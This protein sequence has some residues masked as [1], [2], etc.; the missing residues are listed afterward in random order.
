V[1]RRRPRIKCFNA[2]YS[3]G[4]FAS[5]ADMGYQVVP[6]DKIVGSVG[7]CQEL[8]QEFRPLRLT[9]ARQRRLGKIRSLVDKGAILPPVDLYRLK[10]EYFVVD[11]NHRVAVAKENGQVG[12][13][14]HV[15][16]FLPDGERAEDRLYLDHRAFAGDTGLDGIQLSQVGGYERLR[17]Q[18]EG[19][20]Q[21]PGVKAGSDGNLAEAADGWYRQ[22]FLPAARDLEERR[23]PQRTGKTAGDLYLDLQGRRAFAWQQEGRELTWAEAI[24]QIEAEY[25]IP[26]L[27]ERLADAWDGLWGRLEAWRRG[28]RAE[29]L[30]CAYAQQ[31]PDGTVYCRRAGRMRR[32]VFEG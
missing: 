20:R 31:A 29:E 32:K 6:V 19:H 13:D 25:P 1:L 3:A 27:R 5:R 2:T 28:L 17:E 7:R 16:E 11:G 10:D 14:A 12:I 26:T 15:I 21:Q 9:R 24:E 30:P 22:A 23:L 4:S 8:D 18:I